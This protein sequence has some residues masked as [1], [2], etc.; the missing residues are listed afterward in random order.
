MDE[1]GGFLL[2]AGMEVAASWSKLPAGNSGQLFAAFDLHEAVA[3]MTQLIAENSANVRA[4]F[5]RGAA[6]HALQHYAEALVDLDVVVECEPNHARAWLLRSEIC[7][8]LSEL[9]QG[10]ADRAKAL[11]LDPSLR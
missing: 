4:R 1:I 2:R 3:H 7:F 11:T 6:L 10:Q 8:A 5:L 9:T